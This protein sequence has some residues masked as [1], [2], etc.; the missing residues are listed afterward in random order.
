M[1]HFSFKIIKDIFYV[2]SITFFI[3]VILEITIPKFVIPYI[4]LNIVL[5]ITLL[6]GILTVY[7]DNY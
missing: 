4:N 7:I 2:L 6:S 5:I 1:K 3:F